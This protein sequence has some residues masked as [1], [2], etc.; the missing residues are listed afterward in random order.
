MCGATSAQNSLQAED[1]ST[2]QEYNSAFQQQYAN[3]QA[4]YGKVS[5]VLDPILAAGPNQT[6]F[7]T[8]EENTLN[9][10]AVEGTAE[11]YA[12]AA[13]A[14]GEQVAAEGGGNSPIS[15]GGQTELK[16]QVANS[17][18]QTESGEE[19]Q[20]QEANYNQGRSN[21]EN[22][23]EGEMAIASGENPLGYASAATSQANT[24]GTIANQIAQENNSWYSAALGAAGSVGSSVVGMNPGGIFGG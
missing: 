6:G 3:Q 11:N 2:L 17:A 13:K 4:I 20:I 7:S 18:A 8:G 5:S 22:A 15:V 14:V 19:T 24:T 21:F 10:Q 12:G 16:Q 1:L 23:E 9:S